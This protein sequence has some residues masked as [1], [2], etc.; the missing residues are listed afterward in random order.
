[1]SAAPS[2]SLVRNS[3]RSPAPHR[4]LP[5]G[6]PALPRAAPTRRLHG[7]HPLRVVR[8]RLAGGEVVARRRDWETE[9]GAAVDEGRRQ[10]VA[11]HRCGFVDGKAG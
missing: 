11:E 4:D 3:A 8:R 1:M 5:S 7:E 2:S 9:V 6:L 10:V